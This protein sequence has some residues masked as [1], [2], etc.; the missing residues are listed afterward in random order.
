MLSKEETEKAKERISKSLED[1]WFG[2]LYSQEEKAEDEKILLQYVNQLEQENN[3]QNKIIDAMAKAIS[4]GILTKEQWCPLLSKE[5]GCHAND[6]CLQCL[7]QYFEK[8]VE[9]KN[10]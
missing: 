7:K 5:G 3:K 4:G 9:S 1:V 2:I 10:E 6:T 8:K